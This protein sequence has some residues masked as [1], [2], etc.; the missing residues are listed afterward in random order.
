MLLSSAKSLLREG[1]SRSV[2]LLQPAKESACAEDSHQAVHSLFGSRV[3][4]PP[5]PVGSAL[6]V[7]RELMEQPEG[8]RLSS[9]HVI[10]ASFQDLYPRR[11]DVPR[12]IGAALLG[13]LWRCRL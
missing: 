7:A 12:Q 9:T 5:I 4:G 6:S 11:S 13:C 3:C 10:G 1:V 8:R 2:S